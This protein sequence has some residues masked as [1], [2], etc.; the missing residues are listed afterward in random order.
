[1]NWFSI[2]ELSSIIVVGSLLYG[3]LIVFF[4]L[5]SKNQ[6]AKS[7]A[8]YL[9][10]NILYLGSSVVS[11]GT[12]SEHYRTLSLLLGGPL[13]YFYCS[14]FFEEKS[15]FHW[16]HFLP[17]IIAT[18]AVLY[19]Y[20]IAASVGSNFLPIVI[21]AHLFVYLILSIKTVLAKADQ[22][23]I[24]L[25]SNPGSRLSWFRNFVLYQLLIFLYLGYVLIF[26]NEVNPLFHVSLFG[27]NVLFV[28]IQV[29]KE[30]S[31]FNAIPVGNKYA[32]S[33]LT[34]D[35][36]SAIVSKLERLMQDEKYYTK[37]NASLS[38]LAQR[39]NT[40]AHNLSQV[41][42]ESQKSSFFDMISRYRI[43]AAKKLLKDE[44]HVYEKVEQIADMVG[45][46]SK[47]AFNTAFKKLTGITPSEYRDGKSV[48]TYG[49]ER[50]AH[51]EMRNFEKYTRTFG[52]IKINT[53]MLQ[54]FLKIFFRNSKK[55]KIFSFLNLFGL[56]LGFS[57]S[58]LIYLF[59]QD[60]LSYDKHLSGSERIYRIY[61][62]DEN[63]QTR[64][65]HPMAQAM[66]RDFPEVES[67]VSISPWYGSGLS[68]QTVTIL[69]KGNNI[70][71]EEADFYFADSTFF[72]VFDY[73][74][75][76]GNTIDPL[77]QPNG[78]IL[79]EEMAAKYF[80][81][82]DP[83][84]MELVI[85]EGRHVLSVI[86]VVE[87][88]P[89]NAHFHFNF[90]YSYVNL[91]AFNPDNPW[92]QWADMGHFNYIKLKHES[93]HK[94]LEA[95][96]PEWV[97]SYLG[98]RQE[99]I[100]RLLAGEIAFQLQPITSIHLNSH[101]RW[102]LE[103]NGNVLYIYILSGTL[104][105][106][107]L[108]AAIN[109]VNLTTAKSMDRAKEI[110]VKKTL[111]AR[112]GVLSIQFFTESVFFCL[113]AFIL[114]M[115]LSG[116]IIP[117]FND[118]SGKHFSFLDILNI[119]VIWNALLIV[120]LIGLASGVYPSII[121]SRIIPTQILKGKFSNS[122][123]GNKLR[124]SLVVIQ[125]LVSA[126]LICGSLII[127]K[128]INF[129]KSK[130]LGFEKEN[131]ISIPIKTTLI[132][133]K[134][135]SI[136]NELSRIPNVTE[137]S[138]ISNVP[139][140]QFNQNPIYI[141]SNPTNITNASEMQVDFDALKV[142]NLEFLEGRTFDRSY[143]ADSAG[144]SF[145]VN[146][147][148]VAN[149]NI[150][151]PIGTKLIWNDDEMQRTGYIIGVVKDFHYKSLHTLIQ[152]LII[153]IHPI[154][155]NQVLVKMKS[156][157]TQQTLQSIE[158]VYASFDK[159]FTFD[160]VFL[161]QQIDELYQSEVRTLEIFGLF[162]MVALFLAC[163]GLLGIAMA[164]LNQKIK[165]VGIR[166]TLG[167]SSAQITSMILTNF[168]K[169]VFAALLIGLPIA[170]LVMQKWISEFSYQVDIGVLPY[171]LSS[172]VLIIVAIGS[173]SMVVLRIA[174]SNPVNAL[175]YE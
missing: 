25:L 149:L 171:I 163:L 102:E 169:L 152:P 69:N 26:K 44:K 1:M 125:F 155:F 73:K 12:I 123:R 172:I 23:G 158:Q 110:G 9:I 70:K 142:L 129:L 64:T 104:L 13:L 54:N 120:I 131:V 3:F 50:L 78:V 121:M 144:T 113:L 159:D 48:L 135:E 115:V 119:S 109:Y 22:R 89:H 14:A 88:P 168:F 108:I 37:K 173:V 77:S 38:D 49:D 136:Q 134:L 82:Q 59:I 41:L 45:Y 132:R 128:Q 91:K 162:S 62:Q 85:G 32:K 164:T 107:L 157:N 53:D 103:S 146:E 21:G 81:D 36:K 137:V 33:S 100:D 101:L 31:F 80:G 170:W 86:A 20:N 90:L 143:T 174:Y 39:L 79:T 124:N 2:P 8:W 61:W 35:Q 11:D 66:V 126:I 43:R 96:I 147:S 84:G 106:I 156:E 145:I 98:W 93:D 17:F 133:E 68:K 167:A 105:F 95:K 75:I 29:I 27:V 47:S 55:N 5:S 139:G 87:T 16:A 67:A 130:D 165:E 51:R 141:E 52:Q 56:T 138:A 112:K 65:P 15:K 83:I 151:N 116:L 18:A 57:C 58:M 46:N 74:I 118:L 150:D 42:N 10:F 76:A 166:K 148:V 114:A 92:M 28:L 99:P 97:I 72:D 60:E 30:S 6:S 4:L 24:D 140:G 94:I 122:G 71:F 127:L 161:D 160:Y 111:G 154:D 175:R 63:P 19:S 153:Q 34:P 7:L 40:S 117:N